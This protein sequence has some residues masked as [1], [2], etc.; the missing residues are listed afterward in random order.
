VNHSIL[1]VS[2]DR[3]SDVF[4]HGPLLCVHVHGPVHPAGRGRRRTGLRLRRGM[5]RWLGRGGRRDRASRQEV[6]PGLAHRVP[7]HRHH[8]AQR[9]H[10]HLLRSVR[11]LDAVH[12]RGIHGLQATLLTSCLV[13]WAS[14]W[15]C[16]CALHLVIM[17][18]KRPE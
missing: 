13:L 15:F 17:S 16:V 6:W 1:Y 12:H 5:L 4:V 11:R 3:G 7:R 2:A 10:R 14:F 8:G 9:C 18:A